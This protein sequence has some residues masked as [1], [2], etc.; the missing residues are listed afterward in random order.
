MPCWLIDE[1]THPL[2]S[3]NIRKSLQLEGETYPLSIDHD[4][5][6]PLPKPRLSQQPHEKE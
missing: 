5:D 6:H 2:A 4:N 1:K 3:V